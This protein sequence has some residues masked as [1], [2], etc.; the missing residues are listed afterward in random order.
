MSDARN[1]DEN[2]TER[3]DGSFSPRWTARYVWHNRWKIVR[4]FAAAVV[5]VFGLGVLFNQFDLP[6]WS[7]YLLLLLVLVVYTQFVT[8][9]ERPNEER[10]DEL[11]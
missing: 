7:Y 1:G 11:R 6:A 3:E 8:P 9:W 2:S 5:V 10:N 4:D